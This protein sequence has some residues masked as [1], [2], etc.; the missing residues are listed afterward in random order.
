MPAVTG[1]VVHAD[2]GAHAIGLS[3]VDAAGQ[4]PA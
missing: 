3:P 2:G 1:S 4:A